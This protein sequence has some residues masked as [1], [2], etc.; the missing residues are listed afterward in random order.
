[1]EIR[2]Y[3]ITERATLWDEHRR[4]ANPHIMPVD[5]SQ[6]LYDLKQHMIAEIRGV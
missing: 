1:M 2:E 3:A 6:R 4:F 5:L